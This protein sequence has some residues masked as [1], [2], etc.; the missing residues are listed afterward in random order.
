MLLGYAPAHAVLA[1]MIPGLDGFHLLRLLIVGFLVQA[2]LAAQGV[3]A[4]LDG[5]LARRPLWI[6]A[7]L[8]FLAVVV[9]DV[10]S[11]VGASPASAMWLHVHYLARFGS[12]LLSPRVLFPFLLMAGLLTL[13]TVAA[14]KRRLA[15]L[16]AWAL[17]SSWSCWLGQAFPPRQRTRWHGPWA[18]PMRLG[19]WRPDLAGSWD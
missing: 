19:P 12:V 9:M 18:M 17:A 4:L 1:A 11:R 3:D 2:Y 16:A 10:W 7:G 6:L 5:R 14:R 8:M 15:P 13:A